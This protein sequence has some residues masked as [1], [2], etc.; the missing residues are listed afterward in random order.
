MQSTGELN[1]RYYAPN[2]RIDDDLGRRKSAQLGVRAKV[3][4]RALLSHNKRGP[5]KCLVALRMVHRSNPLPYGGEAAV[6]V[7]ACPVQAIQW[8]RVA[9][10]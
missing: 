8:L 6:M 5:T 10:L 3:A 1:Y 4:A 7:N 2:A 9:G